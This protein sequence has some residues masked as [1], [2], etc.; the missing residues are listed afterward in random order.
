MIEASRLS[1]VGSVGWQPS[2]RPAAPAAAPAAL[3]HMAITESGMYKADYTILQRLV[4]P[5]PSSFQV[6]TIPD[7]VT[8]DRARLARVRFITPNE[9]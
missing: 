3:T 5:V 7:R 2:P 6:E 4:F 1:R 9:P 8:V